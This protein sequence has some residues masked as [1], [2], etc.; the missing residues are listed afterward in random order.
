M[1]AGKYD[2]FVGYAMK[3]DKRVSFASLTI[4]KEYWTVK[5]HYVARKFIETAFAKDG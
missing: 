2:W 5:A 1:P 4:N 3:G